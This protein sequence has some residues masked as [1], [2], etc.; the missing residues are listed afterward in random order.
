MYNQAKLKTSVNLKYDEQSQSL[1]Y[2]FW[3]LV[4][5][6]TILALSA[7]FDHWKYFLKTL[8]KIK[9]ALNIR[10]NNSDLMLVK[11]WIAHNFEEFMGTLIWNLPYF[12]QRKILCWV[13]NRSKWYLIFLNV[14]L[15]VVPKERMFMHYSNFQVD[16][17]S[18][19]L[20][21]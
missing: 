6:W 8:Q 2:M 12:R 15:K 20:F 11:I 14:P 18:K 16:Y 1:K 9:I 21:L 5:S 17:I 19:S 3:L 13:S 7:L 10:C 4:L